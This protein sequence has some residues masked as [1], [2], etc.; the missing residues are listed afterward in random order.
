[1]VA[2]SAPPTEDGFAYLRADLERIEDL[3][4]ALEQQLAAAPHFAILVNN[5]GGPPPGPVLDA[6]PEQFLAA[7][8]QDR[9]GLVVEEQ[10]LEAAD[11][12]PADRG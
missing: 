11:Q 8:R 1:M 12:D 2:R 5:G 3:V 7:F 4:H 9:N 10:D 6:A